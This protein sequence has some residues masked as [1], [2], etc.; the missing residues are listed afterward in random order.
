MNLQYS[1][2]FKSIYEIEAIDLERVSVKQPSFLIMLLK[3]SGIFVTITLIVFFV[4]N[5]QFIKAQ[6][7][8][9]KEDSM[10]QESR[11][12]NNES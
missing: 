12:V 7:I 9:W 3:A 2:K 4:V 5:Y 8:D 11:S 6:M 10:N 1:N